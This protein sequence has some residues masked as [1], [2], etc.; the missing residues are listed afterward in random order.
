MI[1]FEGSDGAG[2]TTLIKSFQELSGLPIAPRV[3]SKDAEAMVD[4]KAWVWDNVQHGFQ[5]TIYDR[6][7]LISEYIYGPILRPSQEPGFNDPD[8][9]GYVMSMFYLYVDPIIVYCIPP[10]KSVMTNV[11]GDP[12]NKVVENHIE[13]I[14]TAYLQRAMTDLVLRPTRTIIHNYTTAFEGETEG[15]ILGLMAN[16]KAERKTNAII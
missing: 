6:H 9:V 10:L 1:I 14:Y 13:A 7:R 3:V 4:L 8:W 12:D 16:R 5:E 15:L 2:K 11:T